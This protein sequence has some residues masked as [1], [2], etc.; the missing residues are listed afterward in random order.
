MSSGGGEKVGL[1]ERTQKY[2]FFNVGVDKSVRGKIGFI[3]GGRGLDR[4]REALS[5]NKNPFMYREDGTG[6]GRSE[7][8]N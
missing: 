7:R 3:G 1:K 2:G 4:S 8:W 5:T 6:T